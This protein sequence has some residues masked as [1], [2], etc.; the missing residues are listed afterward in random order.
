[1]YEIIN[2]I[3]IGAIA[4][5]KPPE[6]LIAAYSIV[7]SFLVNRKKDRGVQLIVHHAAVAILC[8]NKYN[9]K[10][11]KEILEIEKSTAL[12]M[13][14]K[15][16]KPIRP[17]AIIVWIYQ[18]CWYFPRIV[19]QFKKAETD[20]LDI[21]SLDIIKQLGIL[22]SLE[23]VGVPR[24]FMRPCIFSSFLGTIP[25]IK[26]SYK[27]GNNLLCAHTALVLGSSIAHH[28]HHEIGSIQHKIDRAMLVSY[29]IHMG[30]LQN[31]LIDY[32]KRFSCFMASY[33]V[34]RKFKSDNREWVNIM[35]LSPHIIMHCVL[36]KSGYD[37]LEK[38]YL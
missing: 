31:D 15:M 7:D 30:I 23:S 32:I 35:E 4:I 11:S 12:I 36:S 1:M 18:R 26:M 27:K 10:W 33:M 29:V 16:F 37:I 6:P 38:K 28:S 22:W 20:K 13:A 9:S 17:L 3:V 34:V 25:I 19:S 21:V 5:F 24:K 14:S 2:L 8:R